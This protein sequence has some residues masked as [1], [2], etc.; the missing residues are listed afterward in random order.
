MKIA[1]QVRRT[2]DNPSTQRQKALIDGEINYSKVTY[3]IGP[4]RN[5]L[6]I[7]FEFVAAG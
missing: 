5:E 7:L 1:A 2:S 4:L 6:S 3:F